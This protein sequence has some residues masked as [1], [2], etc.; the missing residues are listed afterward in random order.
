[1]YHVITDTSNKN[2][3]P[4]PVSNYS[5]VPVYEGKM[6]TL[7][8]IAGPGRPQPEIS[9]TYEGDGGTDTNST[10]CDPSHPN[11]CET[12]NILVLDITSRDKQQV[13]CTVSQGDP[14][15]VEEVLQHS[16]HMMSS[17]G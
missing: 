6:L 7:I 14:F 10:A 13:N 3:L 15:H 8:C 1:M 12:E 16:K 11:Y 9:W 2:V 17:Y 5:L 4:V